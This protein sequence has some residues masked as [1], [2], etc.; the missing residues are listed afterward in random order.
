MWKAYMY[1]KEQSICNKPDDEYIMQV[2]KPLSV[3]LQEKAQDLHRAVRSVTDCVAVLQQFRDGTIFNEIFAW[4]TDIN[5]GDIGMPRRAGRQRHRANVPADNAVDYYKRSC[6][7]PFIDTCLSQ[8][9]ERFAE[10]SSVAYLLSALLP[11]YV[12]DIS[13][14]AVTKAASHYEDFLPGDGLTA[15]RTELMRWQNYW[16]RQPADVRRPDSVLDALKVADDLGTYPALSILL[17]IYA[18]LPVTTATGERS[19]SSLKYIKSYLRSTMSEERLNG[20]AHLY[21]NRDIRLQY[22]A[23]I[24]E[25]SRSNRRLSFA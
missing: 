16:Q 1:T 19:F 23:V 6:F 8:L 21:I 13:F 11:A 14:D 12:I 4:A 17:R 15:A 5:G 2:T 7:L 3:K 18:T 10:K 22:D 9:A 25:F 20:L 24:D